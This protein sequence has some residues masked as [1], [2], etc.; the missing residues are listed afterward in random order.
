LT[1]QTTTKVARIATF[2]G[3]SGNILQVNN[4]Q[5]NADLYAIENSRY[6]IVMLTYWLNMNMSLG[7][8]PGLAL[9]LSKAPSEEL[10]YGFVIDCLKGYKNPRVKLHHL[11]K[12]KALIRVKRGVYIFGERFAR[13]PYSSEVLAN[14]MYGPSYVSLEWAC[15]YHRLIPE[16]VTTV[17]SVTTQ[18]SRQFQT[19]LGLFTYDHLPLRA[20]PTGINLIKFSDTQQALIATK[21]KALAD[22]LILRRGAFSSKK[23]FKEILLEDLRVEEEDLERLDLELLKT[24]YQARPHSAI[25]YLIQCRNHE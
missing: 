1:L 9:L 24:I 6:V 17:T 5:Q 10:E 20:F 19:P 12:I 15:Q 13:K 16:K 25:K 7:I 4:L 23:H 14:M 8:D 18:R 21:E 2:S 11:L 3:N 22:L